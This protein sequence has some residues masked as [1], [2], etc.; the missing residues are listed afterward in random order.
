MIIFGIKGWSGL[1]SPLFDWRRASP[2]K[3]N[4]P[5]AT[6]A[7]PDGNNSKDAK[8]AIDQTPLRGS[9]N[10]LPTTPTTSK[11]VKYPFAQTFPAEAGK[12]ACA[13]RRTVPKMNGAA[14][15]P[16]QELINPFGEWQ[17]FVLYDKTDAPSWNAVVTCLGWFPPWHDAVCSWSNYA[18]QYWTYQQWWNRYG[19]CCFW[20]HR[21]SGQW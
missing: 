21:L 19:H 9:S 17:R 11:G 1:F 16:A 12:G 14:Y 8:G 7:V 13:V 2:D 5:H 4:L 18:H 10:A 15:K 20:E 3:F 6:A